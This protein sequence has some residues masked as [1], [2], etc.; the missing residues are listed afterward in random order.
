M[1]TMIRTSTIWIVVM[2]A[3]APLLAACGQKGPLYLQEPP[4]RADGQES[5]S[6]PDSE[7]KGPGVPGTSDDQ[8]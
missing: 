8:K 4:K 3:T 6:K 5:P 2:V 7:R 1:P